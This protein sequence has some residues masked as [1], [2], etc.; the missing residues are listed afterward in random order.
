MGRG[1][2]PILVGAAVVGATFALAQAQVFAPDAPSTPSTGGDAA[3]GAV[4]FA[5]TCASCHGEGGVGG[6]PGPR[7][8]GS[9]L[10]AEE[11][12]AVVEQGRGVMPPALVSGADRADVAAYVASIAGP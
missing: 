5:D 6:N 4:V 1:W 2:R 10:D 7:L 12:A 9:G 11:V 3:Q 8:V